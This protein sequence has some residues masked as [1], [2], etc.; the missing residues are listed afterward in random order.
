[1]DEEKPRHGHVAKRGKLGARQ[2]ARAGCSGGGQATGDARDASNPVLDRCVACLRQAEGAPINRPHETAARHA[3]F[4]LR[5]SKGQKMRRFRTAILAIPLF[6]SVTVAFSQIAQ[7]SATTPP[8]VA[9]APSVAANQGGPES[10]SKSSQP[11]APAGP[12]AAGSPSVAASA[13]GQGARSSNG[14]PTEPTGGP[15][16]GAAPSIANNPASGD[17]PPR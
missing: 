15:G 7:P 3:E 12:S 2:S 14:P 13:G 5:I 9:A 8:G 6:P 1:M 11:S 17:A 16:A 4:R 10:A